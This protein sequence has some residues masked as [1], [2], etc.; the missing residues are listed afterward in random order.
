MKK[1]GT[2][3]LQRFDHVR[4]FFRLLKDYYGPS[5]FEIRLIDEFTGLDI[6]LDESGGKPRGYRAKRDSE[7][8]SEAES[9]LSKMRPGGSL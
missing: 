7:Y 6:R 5:Y 4:G 1:T 8:I 2:R 9:I 3:T